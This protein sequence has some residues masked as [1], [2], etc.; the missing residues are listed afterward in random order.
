L[1]GQRRRKI[2]RVGEP[3]RVKVLRVNPDWREIDFAPVDMAPPAAPP[4]HRQQTRPG[5]QHK[6]R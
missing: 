6:K 1:T 4:T 3:L 2:W 5:R